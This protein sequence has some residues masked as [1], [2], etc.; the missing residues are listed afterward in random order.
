MQHCM[1]QLLLQPDVRMNNKSQHKE[2]S[3]AARMNYKWQE[4]T[5]V[6]ICS[7][8]KHKNNRVFLTTFSHG[9]TV[10]IWTFTIVSTIILLDVLFLLNS[11]WSLC[12]KWGWETL[13]FGS[14]WVALSHWK[15]GSGFLAR[16]GLCTEALPS[17][18]SIGPQQVR[19]SLWSAR[20][21][22]LSSFSRCV[23]QTHFILLLP[24]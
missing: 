10:P 12:L 4:S 14:R 19:C 8:S 15:I 18:I 23:S 17:V 22:C 1:L 6:C 11:D 7:I 2:V 9:D 13:L 16:Y 21:W 20:W 5:F 24:L 3:P